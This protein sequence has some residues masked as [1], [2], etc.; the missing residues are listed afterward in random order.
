[1]LLPSTS[2]LVVSAMLFSLLIAVDWFVWGPTFASSRR[3][4]KQA[5]PAKVAAA[6]QVEN[7]N[8][9]FKHVA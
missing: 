4:P 1:M 7:E 9:G 6:D 8:A 3:L 2:I 5:A